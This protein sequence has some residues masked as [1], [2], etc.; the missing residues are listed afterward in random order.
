MCFNQGYLSALRE[1]Y[2]GAT[3]GG[4]GF[5]RDKRCLELLREGEMI[6]L[7]R[8]AEV[9]PHLMVFCELFS[10]VLLALTDQEFLQKTQSAGK[11]ENG[12]GS[13]GKSE[14]SGKPDGSRDVSRNGYRLGSFFSISEIRDMCREFRDVA[15]GLINCQY[16]EFRLKSFDQREPTTSEED[17]AVVQGLFKV[18]GLSRFFYDFS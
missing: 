17:A 7:G 16:P 11:S 2:K 10:R 9:V 15:L 12:S 3:V 13:V 4:E 8:R 18:G 14:I 6:P 1:R 5:A